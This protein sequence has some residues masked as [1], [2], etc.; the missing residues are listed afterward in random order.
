M[1]LP[2]YFLQ[3]RY[4]TVPADAVPV[5]VW[6]DHYRVPFPQWPAL[7]PPGGPWERMMR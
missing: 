6:R 3:G 4:A 7:M 5:S 1:L 2:R